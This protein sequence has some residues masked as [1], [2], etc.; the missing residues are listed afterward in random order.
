MPRPKKC[1]RVGCLPLSSRFGPLEK[2]KCRALAERVAM[3]VDEYECIR[4]IDHQGMNQEECAAR[5]GIART[6]AQRIYD[7]ARKKL[8]LCLVECRPLMIEGGD[9]VVG[10]EAAT[11]SGDDQL[12]ARRKNSCN[13]CAGRAGQPAGTVA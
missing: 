6:T 2:G 10:E 11:A 1:R 13:T 8:A 7:D 3:T 4:L 5:M 12:C 9:Y